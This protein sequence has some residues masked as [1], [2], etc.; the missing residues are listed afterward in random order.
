MHF[1]KAELE[2][3]I[4]DSIV[5]LVTLSGGDIAFAQKIE[6]KH[7]SYFIKSAAFKHAKSLFQSEVLGL[8]TL[9]EINVIKVP[10]IFGVFD[11][12]PSSC[13]IL[14]FIE[15]KTP[16]AKD[17]IAFGRALAFM[18]GYLPIHSLA[19]KRIILLV[20]SLNPIQ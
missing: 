6:T 2:S 13:L 3:F 15:N 9:S 10:E 19:L 17:M 20:N 5:S 1:N 16:T 11:S 8:E 12:G 4:G 14:E 7:S 18:H